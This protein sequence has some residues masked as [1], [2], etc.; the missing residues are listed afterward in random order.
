MKTT[1]CIFNKTRESFLALNV[2]CAGTQL[3][4]LKGLVGVMR[5]SQGEGL[6]VIPSQGIHTIG[7][8]FPI[9]VVYLDSK[10]RVIH[11]VEHL[12]PFR[13]GPIRMKC[14]SVLELPPHVIYESQTQV[15][16]QM[17]IRRPEEME[18]DVKKSGPAASETAAPK[19]AARQWK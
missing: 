8:L 2:T 11:L 7:V 6:W 13:L 12:R 4:R 18:M 19:E 17:L 9:D 10:D 16:D 5:V 1:Y 15:G 3:A 14:A